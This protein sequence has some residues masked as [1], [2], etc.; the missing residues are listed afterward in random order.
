MSVPH[1][2][3]GDRRP[4]NVPSRGLG[5]MPFPTPEHDAQHRHEL[6][7]RDREQRELQVARDRREI[8][9]DEAR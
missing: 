5:G 9:E 4:T 7:D 6:D 8:R 3:R 1:V 2:S